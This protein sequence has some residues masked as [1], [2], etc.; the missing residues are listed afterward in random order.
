MGAAEASSIIWRL[1]ELLTQLLFKLRVEGLLLASGE[2]RWLGTASQEVALALDRV[3]E[4]ELLRGIEVDVLATEL[5]LPPGPTLAEL[6]GALAPPWDAVFAE[7]RAG[8]VGISAEL[9]AAAGHNRTLLVAGERAVAA[10]LACDLAR[11]RG[12][13]HGR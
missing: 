5:G 7:H 6:V 2:A 4:V 8:L 13:H 10:T 3:R 12:E 11:L 1:R 9:E